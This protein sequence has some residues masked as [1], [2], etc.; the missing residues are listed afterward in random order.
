M[1]PA[2]SFKVWKNQILQL[3]NFSPLPKIIPNFTD[4]QKNKFNI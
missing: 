2:S 1:L 3:G 4:L